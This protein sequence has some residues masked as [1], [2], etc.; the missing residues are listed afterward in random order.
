MIECDSDAGENAEKECEDV[1]DSS[2]PAKE[3]A[4]SVPT[5]HLRYVRREK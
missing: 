1:R 4:Y 2:G 5:S 3:F